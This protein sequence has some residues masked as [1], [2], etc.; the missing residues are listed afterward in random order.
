M[1]MQ[2]ELLSFSVLCITDSSLFTNVIEMVFVV[3]FDSQ[4]E[5]DY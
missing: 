3:R 1:R 5:S 2:L 4:R